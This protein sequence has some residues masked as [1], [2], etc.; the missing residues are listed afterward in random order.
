MIDNCTWEMNFINDI[1]FWYAYMACIIWTPIKMYHTKDQYYDIT[2]QL[3]IA[4]IYNHYA[5]FLFSAIYI[6]KTINNIL[7]YNF[8]YNICTHTQHPACGPIR[9]PKLP[10]KTHLRKSLFSFWKVGQC[11]TWPCEHPPRG[12]PITSNPPNNGIIMERSRWK[13]GYW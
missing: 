4:V 10:C 5:Y 13:I 7:C 6:H 3:M 9:I 8:T 12:G 2:N 1:C 11:L